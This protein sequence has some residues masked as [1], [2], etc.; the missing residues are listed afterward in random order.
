MKTPL[1]YLKSRVPVTFLISPTNPKEI[2][3]IIHSLDDTKSSGP[4]P[5]PIKLLKLAADKISQP[6][7][8]ICNSSFKQG[9]FP[10]SNKIAK[11]VP[12][13]KADSTKDVNNYRPISLLSIFSKIM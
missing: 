6:L 3:D 1:Y 13:H 4:C 7:N 9:I 5:I 11:V 12:I 2:T 8:D 10:D